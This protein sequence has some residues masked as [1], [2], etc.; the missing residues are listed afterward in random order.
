MTFRF[1]AIVWAHVIMIIIFIGANLRG[2]PY[3]GP[4]GPDFSFYRQ[5]NQTIGSLVP[6]GLWQ[7]N[8]DQLRSSINRLPAVH[9]LR[10]IGNS[11]RLAAGQRVE[12]VI[13]G[14]KKPLMLFPTLDLRVSEGLNAELENNLTTVAK[15]IAGYQRR[16]IA[17]GWTLVVM[18]I[19]TK[20][21]I[22]RELC[23]WPIYESDLI[24]LRPLLNDHSDEVYGFLRARLEENRIPNVDLQTIYRQ[25]INRDPNLLLYALNDTHWSG[26]GIRLAAQATADTIALMSPLKSRTPIDPTFLK[27]KHVGDLVKAHDPWSGFTT[28][29]SP[30]WEFDDLLL[31]GEESKGYTYPSNPVGIVAAVGTSFTGHYSYL[32][33]QLVTFP[34]QLSLHL[35]NVEVQSRAFSGRGAFECFEQ[36]WKNRNK[37]AADFADKYGHDRPKIVVWDI[38]VRG[39]L[40]VLSHPTLP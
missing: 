7:L 38:P 16:L 14:G 2:W 13:W 30:V 29:L 4:H 12:W 1:P 25:A 22:H 26:A 35:Q 17:E 9:I 34:Q 23:K 40:S 28:W 19:P 5:Q 18:P 8:H 37:I 32:H 27:V 6:T 11:L 31:N 33:D 39:A 21:G 20:L 36:F 10:E 3:P 15:I 24:N